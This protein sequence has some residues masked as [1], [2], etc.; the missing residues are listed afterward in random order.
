MTSPDSV[1]SS[2]S[3]VSR[4]ARLMRI[5]PDRIAYCG[6]FGRPASRTLGA[7]VVYLSLEGPFELTVNGQPMSLEVFALLPPWTLH[8]VMTQDPDLAV[9]LLEP[10]AVDGAA[11]AAMLMGSPADRERFA[12]SIRRGFERDPGGAEDFD[13]QFFGVSLPGR[14]IDSRIRRAIDLVDVH[15]ATDM[16]AQQCAKRIFLSPSHFMHLFRSQ[17]DTTFRRFRAWKRARR[18][19]CVLG[20]D[21]RLVEVALD[22]GYADSTHL[23]RAVRS[24]FGYTPS[25]MFNLTRC[26]SV[27][28]VV[29]LPA[30]PVRALEAE[31][32]CLT[33]SS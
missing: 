28:R 20:G 11:L 6:N 7:W 12:E 15:Q 21:P 32:R 23:C 24:F 22:G 8:R 30:G 9:I 3:A 4:P 26:L 17:M 27:D 31:R 1:A 33:A 25:A 19:L 16:T 10:E 5:T 2:T 18:L 29:P 14:S 13:Q